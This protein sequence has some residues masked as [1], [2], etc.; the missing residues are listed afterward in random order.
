MEK[1]ARH[2]A[3]PFGLGNQFRNV[4]LAKQRRRIVRQNAHHIQL[5]RFGNARFH[6]VKGG[7]PENLRESRPH[8]DDPPLFVGAKRNIACRKQP[9]RG[10]VIRLIFR[11]YLQ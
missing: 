4:T 1:A 7:F 11:E 10:G 8:F 6:G 2:N 9:L 5:I 3:D